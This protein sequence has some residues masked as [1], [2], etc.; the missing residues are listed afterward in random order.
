VALLKKEILM[1]AILSRSL[2]QPLYHRLSLLFVI[3]LLVAGPVHAAPPAASHVFQAQAANVNVQWS[4]S[5][6]LLGY[7]IDPST[8]GKT[9][10]NGNQSLTVT[11]YWQTIQKLQA[12]YAIWVHLVT[13]GNRTVN[14]SD[15]QPGEGASPTSGWTPGQTVVDKHVLI[16][17]YEA[18]PGAYTVVVSV[19]RTNTGDRIPLALASGRTSRDRYVLPQYVTVLPPLT[20]TPIP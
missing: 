11:L 19:Y 5:L 3:A 13:T 14:Q 8:N 6:V 20:L 4:Q 15:S 12:D 17:P 7:Q 1:P 9:L 10:I 16:V 18:A 2:L